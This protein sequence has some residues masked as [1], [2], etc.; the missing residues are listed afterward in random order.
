MPGNRQICTLAVA[1]LA[2][3]F[4]LSQTA[5]G[6]RPVTDSQTGAEKFIRLHVVANSD[7]P[8]DQELKLV[9]K[10][11]VSKFME[12]R[13]AC[14]Q[15]VEEARQVVYQNLP[16]IEEIAR[17]E[18]EAA[19]R[20]YAVKAEMGTFAFPHKNYGSFILPA[21]N[22]EAVRIVIGSGRGANWWC[23]LFPPLCFIDSQTA[24]SLES[25]AAAET[26]AKGTD[27]SCSQNGAGY[28]FRFRSLEF[29][30]TFKTAKK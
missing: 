3:L 2:A 15:N 28:E 13:L 16:V 22:Y 17:K 12:N 4:A 25:A 20:N 6:Y 9:V 30:K 8:Q 5:Q 10:D 11:A 21:G 14:A 27:L 24:Q 19:G 23:V 7:K 29:L 1:A 26:Q 18:V